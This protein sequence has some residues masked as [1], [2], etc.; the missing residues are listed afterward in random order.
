MFLH[1]R[2]KIFVYDLRCKAS[3]L[4]NLVV[5]LVDIGSND[6]LELRSYLLGTKHAS[7]LLQ[8][9]D[10]RLVRILE[11]EAQACCA[12]Q[13]MGDV[14]LAPDQVDNMLR[15]TSIILCH[16]HSLLSVPFLTR[17]RVNV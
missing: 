11:I 14:L 16:G 4:E 6:Y 12:V 3:E 5:D 17:T 13:C 2:V 7:N 8:C 9:R 1:L 15:Y 10:I